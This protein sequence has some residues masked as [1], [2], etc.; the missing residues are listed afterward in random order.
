MKH[1]DYKNL[2][3]LHCWDEADDDQKG[4]LKK[5]LLTCKE[6]R[7]ELSEI[8]GMKHI[9]QD[10]SSIEV[11]D[12]MLAE[13]RRELRVALR[14]EKNKRRSF[15]ELLEYLSIFFERPIP[16][17]IGGV[18]LVLTG[19]LVGYFAFQPSEPGSDFRLTGITQANTPESEE[20]QITNF[21]LTTQDQFSG[22]VE[23]EFD[24]ITPVKMRGTADDPAIQK[25][26]A[27]TLLDEQNPGARLR[28][29]TALASQMEKTK[30][31][32]TETKSALIFSLK[33]DPNDGVRKEAL[34]TLLQFPMDKEIKQALTYVLQK[35][36]NPAMRIEAIN[37]LGKLMTESN[38]QDTD[39]LNVLKEKMERDNNNYI[40]I[41]ASNL[42]KE[43][44]Q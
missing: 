25:V 19:L 1:D 14:L 11:T 12:D 4:I 7:I 44:Q 31:L 35:D 30:R 18:S 21:R 39:I 41:R 6:C 5:H 34:R 42:L 27:Q 33:A 17:A 37:S 13:A 20:P 3:Y 38:S 29:V 9:L 36:I 24:L 16:I 15:Q 43:I 32:D 10:Q 26:L 40:R 23:I 22:Q 2:L 8:D 28:T